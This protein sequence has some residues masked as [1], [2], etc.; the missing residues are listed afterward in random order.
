MDFPRTEFGYMPREFWGQA[1][2]TG[3]QL[4]SLITFLKG[5]S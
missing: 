4:P 1:G 5:G 2:R 3:Y